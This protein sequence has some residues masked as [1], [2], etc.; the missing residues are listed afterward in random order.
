MPEKIII[1]HE[2]KNCIFA[3]FENDELRN[4]LEECA[5]SIDCN[6]FWRECTPD[7][8]AVPYFIGIVDRKVLGDDAW[9]LYLDYLEGVFSEEPEFIDGELF[10]PDES[11]LILIDEDSHFSTN[12][13]V[14]YF[15]YSPNKVIEITNTV[16]SEY[17]KIN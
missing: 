2:W 11:P 1:S 10:K 16:E 6:I 12:K 7:I 9:Q 4:A 3:N 8:I 14:K 17:R 5:E 13:L 15:H